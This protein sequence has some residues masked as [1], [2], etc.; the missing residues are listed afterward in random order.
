MLGQETVIPETIDSVGIQHVYFVADDTAYHISKVIRTDR[1]IEFHRDFLYP[2][3][4]DNWYV[5]LSFDS[6]QNIVVT[7]REY[8]IIQPVDTLHSYFPNKAY[9]LPV[10]VT[11]N[12]SFYTMDELS[13]DAAKSYLLHA[14]GVG[15]LEKNCLYYLSKFRSLQLKVAMRLVVLRNLDSDTIRSECYEMDPFSQDPKAEVNSNGLQLVKRRSVKLRNRIAEY[16]IANDGGSQ[17][18]FV[19]GVDVTESSLLVVGGTRRF[20]EEGLVQA[21]N[22]DRTFRKLLHTLWDLSYKCCR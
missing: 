11:E 18:P 7:R 19:T 8:S 1:T 22:T 14:F 13:E 4:I 21:N 5:I 3:S 6:L 9:P 16:L 17:G 20:F 10:E 2:D 15:S 12:H